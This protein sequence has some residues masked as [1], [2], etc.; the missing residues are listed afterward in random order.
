M[1]FMK[2]LRS[3]SLAALVAMTIA[4]SA[5][6]ESRFARMATAIRT[7]VTKACNAV[8]T[9]AVAAKNAVVAN[10]Q[11][12]PKAYIAAGVLTA[13]AAGVYYLYAK[14]CLKNPFARINFDFNTVGASLKQ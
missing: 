7:N 11:A 4:G 14:G 2:T 8:S 5:V 12:H 9:N 3:L 6:A 1:I 13:S 10:V